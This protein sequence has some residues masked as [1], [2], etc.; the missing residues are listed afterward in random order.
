MTVIHSYEGES[1]AFT[2]E[3]LIGRQIRIESPVPK[4]GMPPLGIGMMIIAD[5]ELV[6]NALKLEL[7]IEP[8]AIVEA[9]L[10]LYQGE[11]PENEAITERVTLRDN[12]A[13]SFSAIASEVR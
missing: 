4:E 13:M 7:S 11:T 10:T 6:N 8:N 5:N 2:A 3:E 1:R 12:I 9:I